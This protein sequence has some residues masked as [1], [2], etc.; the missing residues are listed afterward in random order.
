MN[1]VQCINKLLNIYYRYVYVSVRLCV[2]VCARVVSVHV[3]VCV[4]N[5]SFVHVCLFCSDR[6]V[7]LRLS[8]SVFVHAFLGSTE[9]CV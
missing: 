8:V 1:T 3:S 5:G 9:R 4:S 7:C 6:R 2:C